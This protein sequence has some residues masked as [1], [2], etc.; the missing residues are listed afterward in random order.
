M[1]VN[2]G[3]YRMYEERDGELAMTSFC[4]LIERIEHSRPD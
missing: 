4:L 1:H 3:F 2:A